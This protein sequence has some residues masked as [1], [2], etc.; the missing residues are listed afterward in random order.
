VEKI[1]IF[2]SSKLFIIFASKAPDFAHCK[3]FPEINA[4]AYCGSSLMRERKKFYKCCHLFAD[5]V[6]SDESAIFRLQW[7]NGL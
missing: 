6:K 1:L 4:L 2:I 3:D 5:K 7:K